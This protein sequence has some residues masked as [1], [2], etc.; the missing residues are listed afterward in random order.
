MMKLKRIAA[1]LLL[2]AVMIGMVACG[3]SSSRSTVK[4]LLAT[5]RWKYTAGSTVSI[6]LFPN[7]KWERHGS[8][9]TGGYY[10]V[11]DKTLVLTEQSE[12][13]TEEWVERLT[14]ENY[15]KYTLKLTAEEN[16][17][18]VFHNMDYMP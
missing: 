1:L 13:D 5:Y 4:E 9:V 12:D 7:G 14:I 16:E 15:D 18:I 3:S 11:S 6:Y 17:R 10:E 8:S 2:L